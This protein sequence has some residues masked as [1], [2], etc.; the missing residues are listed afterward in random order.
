MPA[1]A[2]GEIWW[3]SL[4]PVVGYEQAG[5]RPVLVVSTDT[6][7][8]GPLGLVVI[9]PLTQRIR[10]FP[11]HIAVQPEETGLK[12]AGAIM[13]DQPRV[14]SKRCL[15]NQ[16]AAGRLGAPIMERI[17]QLLKTVLDLP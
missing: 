13:C 1:P 7:N 4:D 14:I 16:R 6:Y 5:T 15:L 9:V 8:Q 17:D 11:L 12:S 2:R 10:P 3:T